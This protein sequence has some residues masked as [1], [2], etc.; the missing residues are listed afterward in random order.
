MMALNTPEP[1]TMG[2]VARVLGMDRTTLTAALKP[3]GARGLVRTSA[4]PAD[5]RTRRM[6]LTDTGRQQLAAA[7][8]IWRATHEAICREIPGLEPDALRSVLRAIGGFG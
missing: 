5:Q 1:P 4:D 6:V 3:L 7:A 2:S 8:P